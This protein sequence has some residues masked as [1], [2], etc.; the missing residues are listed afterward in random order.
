[1]RRMAKIIFCSAF[2]LSLFL[3]AQR[4]DS[5]TRS[6]ISQ[7]QIQQGSTGADWPSYGGTDLA[8][9]YSA[10]DKINTTNVKKLLPAWIFQTGD[11]QDALQSTPIV[12]DGIMY[13]ST[14][15]SFVYA[16]DGAT[17]RVIWQ[18]KH[19]PLPGYSLPALVKSYGVAVANGKVFIATYD[20][21]VVALDQKTGQEVWKT[22]VDDPTSCGCRISSAAL[23]VKD[24]VVISSSGRRGFVA[25]LDMKTGHQVWKFYTVPSPGEPGN[26]TWAGDSWKK[27]GVDPWVTGSYDPE[28]NLVYWG[29]GD[30]N[31]T[32]FGA[33]R[34]GINLYSCSLLALDADTGKLRW[35]YQEVPHDTWDYDSTWE[36]VLMDREV[37]GRMRKLL[38]HIN[39]G[40]YSWVL[41]RATGEV[42]N[43]YPDNDYINWV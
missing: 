12:V 18:Y 20:E 5:Q 38:V 30:P 31:P 26:E 41:D 23:A 32:F 43:T 22:A 8:W 39:K 15:R 37:G 33:P 19:V 1:M 17:G 16:L 9:R 13:V 35:Y 14:A 24:K 27:G 21:F 40:G 42:L 2:A 7:S 6:V 10:L 29:T 11:Y 25:A 28:L 3:S 4:S 34:E 36:S